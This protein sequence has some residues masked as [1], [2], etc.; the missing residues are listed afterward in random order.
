MAKKKD[1][2]TN[3]LI[4]GGVAVVAWA[5]LGKSNNNGNNNN[6]GGNYSNFPNVPSAPPANTPEWQFWATAIVGTFG[7]VIQLWQPG[8]P[9]YNE[10]GVVDVVGTP[11]ASGNPSTSGIPNSGVPCWENPYQVGC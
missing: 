11:T 8:G 7:N 1:N 6:N 2:T 4:F 9:F 3:I 5:L 10:P